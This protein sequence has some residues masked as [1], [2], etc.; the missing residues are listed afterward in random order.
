MSV[1]PM[2]GRGKYVDAGGNTHE[3]SFKDGKKEGKGKVISASGDVYIGEFKA[4]MRHG[5]GRYMYFNGDYYDG[6][7][8][9]DKKEG[10]GR[11]VWSDGSEE[12]SMYRADKDVGEGVRWS[13]DGTT[14]RRLYSGWTLLSISLKEAE[15]IANRIGL[16]VPAAARVASKKQKKERPEANSAKAQLGAS[17]SGEICGPR[18]LNALGMAECHALPAA[19]FALL[20]P[21]LSL[22]W[23]FWKRVDKGSA[24]PKAR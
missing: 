20:M 21:S 17:S 8:I 14:A 12:I 11:Y 15:R 7:W 4:D 19:F 9:A 18:M 5:R 2:S 23:W 16:P 22:L 6:Q 10:R 13:S 24:K 3:G 1:A